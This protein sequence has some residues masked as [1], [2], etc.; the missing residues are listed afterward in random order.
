MF[1]PNNAIIFAPIQNEPPN[2]ANPNCNDAACEFIPGANLFEKFCSIMA[3]KRPSCYSIIMIPSVRCSTRSCTRSG[4][5][6]RNSTPSRISVTASR[7]C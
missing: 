6:L 1:A 2:A 7:I 5:H 3:A 4:R